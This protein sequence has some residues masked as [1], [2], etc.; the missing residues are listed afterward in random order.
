MPIRFDNTANQ[1]ARVSHGKLP[2]L[3]RR[4]VLL[5]ANP[6]AKATNDRIWQRGDVDGTA[7]E[8]LFFVANYVLQMEDAGSVARGWNV[9]NPPNGS[10]TQL[11]VQYDL[12]IREQVPRSWQNGSEF[13]VTEAT[14]SDG[15][16]GPASALSDP[17]YIGNRAD[18]ARTA[19]AHY[20]E[21]AVW[22]RWLEPTEREKLFRKNSPL[23]FSPDIYCQF[24][25]VGG[26]ELVRGL[27]VDYNLVA[28]STVAH[29]EVL[30]K[31]RPGMI[32]AAKRAW[33]IATSSPYSLDPV[34]DMTHGVQV[35]LTGAFGT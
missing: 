3:G 17:W 25:A 23:D 15:A 28:A 26:P 32:G 20:A 21:F 29:P 27:G 4:T 8:K 19:D 30:P 33:H 5:L 35:S 22:T 31:R 7:P 14:Q 13:N 9:G 2:Q 34:P 11:I 1:Y 16:T 18:G 12:N 10:W 24:R 6:V